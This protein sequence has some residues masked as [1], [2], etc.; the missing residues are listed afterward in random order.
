MAVGVRNWPL[1]N[2]L[3]SFFTIRTSAAGGGGG[4]GGGGGATRKVISCC[5]GNASVKIKGNN[6]RTPI[7]RIWSTNESRVVFPRL[8]LNLPPDSMRLSDERRVGKECRSRW[9]P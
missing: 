8:L 7:S 1:S 6:T 9:S 5:R 3:W 4:G 2:S